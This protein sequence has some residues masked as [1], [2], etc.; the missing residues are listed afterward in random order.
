M[1]SIVKQHIGDV[2]TEA[3]KKQIPLDSD[4]V[5][6]LLAWRKETPYAGDGD[7][8]F[9]RLKMKGKQPY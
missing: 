3:S 8:V 6:E 2:K 1:R 9:A 4:L 7:Y 5:A